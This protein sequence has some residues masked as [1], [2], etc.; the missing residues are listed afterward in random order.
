[1]FPRLLQSFGT[2]QQPLLLGNMSQRVKNTFPIVKAIQQHSAELLSRWKE[3]KDP[4]SAGKSL[5]DTTLRM[6]L[7]EG[8]RQLTPVASDLII[9]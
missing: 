9:A 3:K 1:M 6:K 8:F 7:L 2:N 4:P 5:W